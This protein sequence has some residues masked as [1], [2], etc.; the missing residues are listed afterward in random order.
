MHPTASGPGH[1]AADPAAGVLR[2]GDIDA[3]AAR[4]L[5]ARHGLDLVAVADR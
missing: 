5:L 2:L 4:A 3:A 1:T